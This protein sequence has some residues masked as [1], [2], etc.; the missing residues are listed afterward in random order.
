MLEYNNPLSD[1]DDIISFTTPAASTSSNLFSNAY[2]SEQGVSNDF[3]NQLV[4]VENKEREK[5]EKQLSTIPINEP[6]EEEISNYN[7]LQKISDH[8][9]EYKTLSLSDRQTIKSILK[10]NNPKEIRKKLQELEPTLKAYAQ[11]EIFQEDMQERDQKKRQQQ[12]LSYKDPQLTQLEEERDALH[13][14]YIDIAKKE[15]PIKKEFSQNKRNLRENYILTEAE[16][17]KINT[18]MRG[19]QKKLTTIKNTDLAQLVKEQKRLDTAIEKRKKEIK[20][21]FE[22]K[23]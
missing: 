19:L 2:S 21:E 18:T 10:K 12:M 22:S 17:A 5:V 11:S 16:K 4:E 20:E 7:M 13:D 23:F 14:R 15:D 8:I 9:K 1:D 6:N 3:N